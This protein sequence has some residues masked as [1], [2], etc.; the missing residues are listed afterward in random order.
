MQKI[1][2]KFA[3]I[4][5]FLKFVVHHFIADDCAYRASA[6]AFTTLL[7]IVPLMAVSFAILSIFPVFQNFVLPAQN[8]IFENFV[9][10]TGKLVQNYLQTFVKQASQL[11]GIGIIFL[12]I[13]AF[14]VLYTVEESMNRIWRVNSS[15]HGVFALLMYWSIMSLA[16][17]LLG[18][19]LAATSYILAMP[20]IQHHQNTVIFVHYLPFLLSLFGFTFLYLVVP[21]CKVRLLHA[22]YGAIVAALLFE[23]AKQGFAYYLTHYD[24]YQLLYG[25]F[26]TIPLLFA[27]IYWVWFITL[28]GAEVSYAFSMH[29]QRRTG[30]PL[31]GFSHALI[32]L[33]QLWLAQQ[34]GAGLTME[35]LINV[36]DKPYA[37]E[38]GDML[39]VLSDLQLIQRT[40]EREYILCRDLHRLTL[41]E[42]SQWLPYQLPH[43]DDDTLLDSP[44][45]KRLQ[46]ANAQLK[47]TLSMNVADLF[48]EK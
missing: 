17:L 28:L 31:D 18:L 27:W 46:Q 4:K 39:K 24:F 10:T 40:N 20:F 22:F 11:S 36:S 43:L 12:F 19:S 3:E 26:A 21:N 42:L 15:R 41:Y 34:K 14:L 7:A 2:A 29:H 33:H 44:W 8:F 23:V 1:R 48:K 6:L 9:P 37:I 38:V 47:D 25:A 30:K 35:Q 5:R 13:I 45:Q 16:P 32:W